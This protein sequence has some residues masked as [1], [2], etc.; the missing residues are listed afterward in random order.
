M[1]P[2]PFP[3]NVAG[4]GRIGELCIDRE[5]LERSLGPPHVS[6][7][8]YD[9]LEFLGPVRLWAFELTTGVRFVIEFLIEENIAAVY[10]NASD[11]DA[12]LLETGLK[13]DHVYR[14]HP[15]GA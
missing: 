13:P 10:S 4:A 1:R 5:R 7:D 11:L 12:V 15:R 2:I 3:V 8:D 14:F 9:P 6:I